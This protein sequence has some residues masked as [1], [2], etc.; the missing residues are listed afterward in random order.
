M[1]SPLQ[2]ITLLVT[3][4]FSALFYGQTKFEKAYFIDN[5]E[6]KIE[7]LIKNM[8]WKDNPVSFEYKTDENSFVQQASLKNVKSFEIYNQARYVRSIVKIDRSGSNVSNLNRT[9]DPEFKEEQ[10]FLKVL[11]SGDA[12]LYKYTDKSL[13]RYFYN[14]ENSE[15]E[16]LIYKPYKVNESTMSYNL[17]YRTQLKDNLN[18]SDI[19][20]SDI[21]RINYQE[22]DLIKL[23]LIYNKCKNPDF[24]HTEAQP[25]KGNLNVN[26]RPRVNFSSLEFT[27][28]YA[29]IDN[30]KMEDKLSF[31]L[32][33][34][35]EYVLPFNNNK[36]SLIVEPTY[37]VYKSEKTSDVKSTVA[38]GK[39]ITTVDYQS[40]EIPVGIRHYMYL[41]EKSKMFLNAQYVPDIA[42]NS[43]IKYNVAMN[44]T[45]NN[46]VI[47][48]RSNVALGFGYAY[49][50]RFGVEFRYF[51]GREVLGDY[52]IFSSKY[53]EI[54]FILGYKLF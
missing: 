44:S 37:Q 4:L 40:V 24:Q 31:G 30:Y 35:A 6:R 15:V 1:K 54:S 20:P 45:F 48:S 51:I 47:K 19:T 12:N 7:V 23:F 36:W 16:Q 8:D 11:V 25:R 41:T 28:Y 27:N 2:L 34:E 43:S 33:L 52:S 10:L 9:K 14:T 3:L 49:A 53:N 18:C 50:D 38:G 22:K 46:L 5:S 17:T 29:E 39:L 26:I 32:G 42:I 21:N 13:H